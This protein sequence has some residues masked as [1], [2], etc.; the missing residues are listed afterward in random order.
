MGDSSEQSAAAAGIHKSFGFWDVVGVIVGIVVGTAIFKSPTLVFQNSQGP[1]QAL[2]LW[3]V[4]GGLSLCGALVYAELATTYPRNGGDYEYLGRAYG[5]WLGFLFGWAQLAA[6]LSASIAAMG[7]AFGDYAVRL[8]GWSEQS[9]VGLAALAVAAVAGLNLLGV[10]AGKW[11][12]NLLALVKVL[13]LAAIAL[14]G[15]VAVTSGLEAPP[16]Q[17]A[18]RVAPSLGLALVFVLYAFGGW[19]DAAFVAAEVKQ[20]QRNIPRALLYGLA[21]IT[22]IYL[23]VNAAILLTLGFEAARQSRAPAAD[24]MQVVAGNWGV[25]LVSVLVM[26]S[27]LGAINGMILTGSRIYATIGSDFRLFRLFGQYDGKTGSPIQSIVA[28]GLVALA[29]IGIVGT[30]AGRHAIDRVMGTFGRSAIPWDQYFGGFETLVAATAP[31]FWG[32][33]LLAGLSVVVLRLREPDRPRPFRVPFYPMP[34]IVFCL[35]CGYMLYSSVAY[36]GWLAVVGAAPVAVG[37]PLYIA[38]RYG[39][40]GGETR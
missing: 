2:G 38:S 4:G 14:A 33:F 35:T 39:S 30:E 12:Q 8:F 1:W 13:G 27:A 22:A 19:N 5:R 11:T 21:A 31:V 6:I 32:F 28:Q 24:V 7:Y 23:A 25:R 17:A 16:S 20:P 18:A 3:A 9:A 10:K 26:L 37:L 29:L 36:A 40:R 34:V 15:L